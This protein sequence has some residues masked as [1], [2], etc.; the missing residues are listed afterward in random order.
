VSFSGTELIPDDQP[1]YL[2]VALARSGNYQQCVERTKQK[3]KGWVNLIE[4]L[5]G[6]RL[7]NLNASADSLYDRALLAFL[8]LQPLHEAGGCR[9]SFAE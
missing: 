2:R 5:A 4:K 3:L 1:K 9:S 8:V 6:M 7:H